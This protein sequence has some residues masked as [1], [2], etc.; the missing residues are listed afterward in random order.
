M[1]DQIYNSLTED[2]H[3]P[4]QALDDPWIGTPQLATLEEMVSACPSPP[5]QLT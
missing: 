1:S 2:Q 4:S 3:T 5:Q